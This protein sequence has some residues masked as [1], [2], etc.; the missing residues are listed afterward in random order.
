MQIGH[1]FQMSGAVKGQP[2]EE[3]VKKVRAKNMNIQ[4]AMICIEAG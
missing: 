1:E 4:V 2:L 3:K